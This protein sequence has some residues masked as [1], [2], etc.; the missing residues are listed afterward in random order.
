MACANGHL[1][2]MK[3]LLKL[4]QCDIN[5]K[6]SS[7]NTPLRINLIFIVDW[8][9]GNGL[10]EAAK[11]L[12]DKNADFSIIN[13]QGKTASEDAYDKGIYEISEMILEKEILLKKND[14]Q[15]ENLNIDLDKENYNDLLN[16]ME[17]EVS[18]KGE[19]VEIKFNINLDNKEKNN[20]NK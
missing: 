4:E 7:G 15:E 14:I 9:A 10:K 8:A 20:N 1:E 17:V 3:I 19:D 13:N 16:E 5:N 2:I 11:I 6:N 18:E 12:L